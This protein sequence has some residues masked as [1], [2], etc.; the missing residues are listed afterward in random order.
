MKY[1]LAQFQYIQNIWGNDIQETGREEE[2]PFTPEGNT[3]NIWEKLPN[4]DVK[5]GK[6]VVESFPAQ[7]TSLYAI[8][9]AFEYIYSNFLENQE[10]DS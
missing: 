7:N 2:N 10:K 5:E 9:E 8:W 3:A 1:G 4:W 6:K